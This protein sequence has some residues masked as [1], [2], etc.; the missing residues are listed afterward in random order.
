MW[1]GDMETLLHDMEAGATKISDGIRGYIVLT[2]PAGR[3]G[4]EKT[5]SVLQA[6]S[7][8]FQPFVSIS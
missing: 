5:S 8:R 2:K 4:N 3:R 6:A 1:R 7:L